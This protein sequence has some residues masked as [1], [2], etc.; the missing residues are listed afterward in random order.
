M[1]YVEI[2][3]DNTDRRMPLDINEMTFRR[4]I[5]LKKDQYF[6]NNK[7]VTHSDIVSL[8]ETAGFSRSNPY[9]IVKQGNGH[10]SFICPLDCY[11]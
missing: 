5:G 6:M 1:S 11:H 4:Q 9:Y 3:M 7:I 2:V 10:L 8:L